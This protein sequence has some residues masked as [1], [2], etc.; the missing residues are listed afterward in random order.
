[1]EVYGAYISQNQTKLEQFLFNKNI[2][3]CNECYIVL[4]NICE[5]FR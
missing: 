3:V 5:D 4:P 2:E 1:M